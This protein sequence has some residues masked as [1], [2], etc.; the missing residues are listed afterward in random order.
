MAPNPKDLFNQVRRAGGALAGQVTRR[1]PGGGQG[2]ET[3]ETATP[4]T[5]PKTF[6]ETVAADEAA[7]VRG[8]AK[9]RPG[10]GKAAKGKRA[11]TPKAAK[12]LTGAA[13]RPKAAKGLAG[14]APGP[15]AAKGLAGTAP[16]PKAAKSTAVP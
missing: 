13:P 9:R 10:K 7:G 8:G 5:N 11:A 4:P 3:A 14:T 12:G 16:G 2:Q 15:K 6:T 1:L